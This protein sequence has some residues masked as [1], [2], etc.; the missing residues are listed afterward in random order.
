M[1]LV[2][3]FI[4]QLQREQQP[5]KD[6]MPL[7]LSLWWVVVGAPTEGAMEYDW[8][9]QQAVSESGDGTK[10][11]LEYFYFIS[12]LVM[13]SVNVLF[14]VSLFQMLL[15]YRLL[16]VQHPVVH[17]SALTNGQVLLPVARAF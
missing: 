2:R 17:S 3:P 16:S 15:L 11:D 4:F 12:T 5:S 7:S 10:E 1:R 6:R 9:S 8:G 13:H 14:I